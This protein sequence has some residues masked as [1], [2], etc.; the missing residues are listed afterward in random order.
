VLLVMRTYALYGRA[1]RILWLLCSIAVVA[2]AFSIV[3]G[4]LLSQHLAF[5]PPIFF[6]QWAIF[7]HKSETVF[8]DTGGTCDTG[9]TSNQ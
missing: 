5:D 1:K 7:G 6:A 2:F 9:L 4:C 3:R 8:T